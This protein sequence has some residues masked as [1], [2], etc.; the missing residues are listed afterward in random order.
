MNDTSNLA[1]GQF[2]S[3]TSATA[4][5]GSLV[6]NPSTNSYGTYVP[7]YGTTSASSKYA[8]AFS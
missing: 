1:P 5:Y 2:P 8:Y 6:T 7:G 3:Y 4:K